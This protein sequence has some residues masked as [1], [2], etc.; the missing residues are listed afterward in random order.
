MIGIF[1]FNDLQDLM[2][3][4]VR[5]KFSGGGGGGRGGDT[6]KT[7]SPYEQLLSLPT[8]CFKMFSERSLNDSHTHFKHLSLLPLPI[9]HPCPHKNFDHT[10]SLSLMVIIHIYIM[11]K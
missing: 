3:P 5:L 1:V 4:C 2:M 9:H 7:S 8:P 6:F 10:V 11:N